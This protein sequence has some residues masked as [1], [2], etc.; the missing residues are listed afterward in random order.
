VAEKEGQANT[1]INGATSITGLS[2]SEAD[3]RRAEG[4]GNEADFRSS[5][6]YS[7]ILRQ[8]LFTF[9]NIVLFTVSLVL[10]ILGSPQ[11]A[12]FTATVA[13]MNV[14]IASTQ[15]VRAKRKL[16]QIN[17]LTRPKVTV[18]RDVQEK[19]ID[20]SE[21][22][23][24]DILVVGPG[25]QVVVDGQ[26]IDGSRIDM[27]ES[28]L[29]G[30]S[31]LIRKKSGDPVYSGSFCVNGRAIYEAQKVGVDSLAG[32]LTKG[33]RTFTREYTPLQREVDLVIRVLLLAVIFFGLMVTISY[34]I[35]EEA[36]LLEGVRS[37]SV[38]F[39][40]AP[41]SLFLTIVV[42][43]AFGAIRIADKG[44]LVQQ[45]NSVESL[46]HVTV[47]CLD[48]TG[49]LTTNQI[50]LDE[51][52]VLD[53]SGYEQAVLEN[54]LGA[55]AGSLTAGN[56]TSDAIAEAFEGSPRSIR[57]EVPFS[58]ERKW[59]AVTFAGD[60]GLTGTYVLGAPEILNPN[61]APVRGQAAISLPEME[62]LLD[63]WTA[64][65]RRV[66]LFAGRS[67]GS[68][69]HDE[70]DRPRLPGDLTALGL[71]SFS[72]VL[73]PDARETLAEFART[74]IELKIISGD[75]PQTVTALAQQAGLGGPHNS[76]K[77]V[78][79]PDLSQMDKAQFTQAALETTIFGRITPDQKEE[80]VRVLRKEG[81]YVAMTGDGVNDVLALKQAN[82]GIAMQSGSQATRSVSDIVLLNDSFA[83][84]PQAFI[85]GQRILNGMEDILRLYMTRIF[86]LM[87]LIAMIAMLA[88][89]FPLTP[90]QNSIISIITLT[91]PAFALAV[92]ARP[93]AVRHR[94]LT[95]RLVHFVLPAAI[96]MSAAGLVIY[97]Y[98]V[99]D[100]E[101]TAYAQLT[102]TYGMIAMGLFLVIFV[103]PPTMFWVG[104][105]EYSGDRR[106]TLLAFFLFLLFLLA[107]IAPGVSDF[108]A[109]T[110]LRQVNDYLIIAVITIVWMLVV[111]TVWRS[112]LVDRYLNLPPYVSN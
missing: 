65:G 86:S 36:T 44:A 101:D 98:F 62:S 99:I 75:N 64:R 12:F 70:N 85:E 31:D 74:G 27:D 77:V 104:G 13:L 92:W 78:S 41:S 4:L 52:F 42:A 93:G 81:H 58:S 33:A 2:A 54:I 91:V 94:S 43:Y 55:Y 63:S 108:Y 32:Q 71:L 95:R 105:D 46:C 3:R 97:L 16:D 111:R 15:E 23:K 66:L 6:P 107:L 28:L 38:V 90:S 80:L 76:M 24:G 88:A 57:D 109:L 35:N 79:G 50:T 21:V 73:R 19:Q 61:L 47:L 102:L 14:T 53:G 87:L 96:T 20:R 1:T 83:A 56:R 68:A 18:I 59:S 45:A 17:L 69:L 67:D 106:P 37:A 40:L 84:L 7:E 72:D 60:D 112:G 25:D 82:L 34:F 10:L 8:N 89:G 48:K 51:L 103:E 26:I 5:R 22:V 110:P 29:T 11:D 9:F 49:T 39:G 30:E 100:T